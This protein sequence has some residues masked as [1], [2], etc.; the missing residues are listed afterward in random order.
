[1]I[2]VDFTVRNFEGSSNTFLRV[3]I[4]REDGQT[5]ILDD[6]DFEELMLKLKKLEELWGT[7]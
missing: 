7:Q 3:E 2:T 1:M 4:S 5:L 6:D